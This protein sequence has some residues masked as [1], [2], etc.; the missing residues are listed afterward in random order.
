MNWVDHTIWWHVYPLGFCG[1]QIRAGEHTAAPRLRRLLNWL[2]YAVEL[3]ACPGCCSG[4]SSRR[5]PTA[6]TRSTSTASIRGSAPTR[7]STTSSRVAARAASTCCSTAC[8]AT[9]ARGTPTCGAPSPRGPTATPPACSTSTGTPGGPA[10]RVFEGHG[11]LARLNHG[12]ER[13]VDLVAGVVGRWLDR[14]ASGWRLDA[15]YS[16]DASFWARALPGSGSTA[17]RLDPR[18][19]HPRRLPRVRRGVDGGLGHAV[20]V[21]EGRLVQPEGPQLLR[22]RLDPDQAQRPPR[23]LRAQHLRR[24]PRRHAH[25]VDGGTAASR[26]SRSPSS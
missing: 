7:T 21:V 4:R 23:R 14:G 19:G 12:S 20:R 5:R 24:Q 13:T 25:R 26:S 9:S 8:S 1:A 6:T 10:P 11:A 18:R 17:R 22:A 16:V 2:D 3:G 15:A